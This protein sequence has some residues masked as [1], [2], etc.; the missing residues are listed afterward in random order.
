MDKIFNLLKAL[1][2]D[3][4]NSQR[5]I[6]VKTK[7]SLGMVNTLLQR[8]KERNLIN[9]SEQSNKTKYELTEK[10]KDFLENLMREKTYEKLLLTQ[11]THNHVNT[12]VILAAGDN[13][14]FEEPVGLL[15][16][17]KNVKVIDRI[18]SSLQEFDV[19]QIVIIVGY[20]KELY[21]KY[22]NNKKVELIENDKYK[23]TGTMYSLSLAKELIKGDFLII[24]ADH[25]FE[26]KILNEIMNDESSSCLYLSKP[27]G[28]GNDA[29]VELDRNKNL[30]RIS[31][32]I[33]QFNHIDACLSGIHKISYELFQKML[34]YFKDNTNPYLNYEYVLEYI[35]RIYKLNSLYDDNCLCLNINDEK[36]YDKAKN[37]L[38]PSIKKREQIFD[39]A[40]LRETFS[41]IM[42]IDYETINSVNFAGG[43]TNS[44]YK[45]ITNLGN[46]IM[47]IP[48]KCTETMISRENEKYNSKLGYLLNLNVDTI[49]FSEK[50][51][52]KITKY[53]DH[54]ETL[55]GETAQL[56]ENMKQTTALLYSLHN[57]KA[58]LKSSFDVKKELEKYENIV[59]ESN[60]KYYE[61]YSDVRQIFDTYLRKIKMIGENI[62]PCHNDLVPENLI[63]NEERMYLID[64][65][66]AG[67]NDPMWDLAAHLIECEF[68]QENEELFLHYYFKNE[69]IS[70]V[71]QKK[72]M[73]YKLLQDILWAV[74]TMAKE[75]NGEDFGTY[76]MDRMN[77]A[78]RLAKEYEEKYER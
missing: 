12:A 30:Y 1:A 49:Y 4:V 67:Y 73:I 23:W 57:S 52:I 11:K 50:S 43:M 38:L 29:F 66:Y 17:E 42:D 33:H 13:K 68:T 76:G 19:N 7:F 64:W 59:K 18:I 27:S 6:A 51:G 41:K 14:N 36:Q 20:K 65:E 53:I 9:I 2:N 8:M 35:A 48:G 32:D 63:K 3:E 15:S 74:W 45:V 75:C 71:D 58:E 61:G 70:E 31:K 72:I 37:I 22:L 28:G 21:F 56:E 47:R 77:R 62:K 54:A 55:N 40:I 60:G 78:I 16:L 10:G 24:E 44:N 46:Y 69:I 5:Q 26:K 25:V 34:S 39:E